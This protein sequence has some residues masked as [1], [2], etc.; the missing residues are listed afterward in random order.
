MKVYV[1]ET[2]QSS[3]DDESI[4]IDDQKHSFPFNFQFWNL[5]N[6]HKKLDE[7]S[8]KSTKENKKP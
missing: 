8:K 7:Y 5:Q 3:E 1:E 4:S 2:H 6:N